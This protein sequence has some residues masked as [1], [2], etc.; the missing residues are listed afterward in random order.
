MELAVDDQHIVSGRRQQRPGVSVLERQMRL[1]AAKINAAV[2]GPRRVDQRK[3]HEATRFPTTSRAAAVPN[4]SSHAVNRP[5]PSMTVVRG[6]HPVAA[7]NFDVS[8]T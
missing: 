7:V 1:A 4:F 2:E 6:R 5:T 3:L 8:E